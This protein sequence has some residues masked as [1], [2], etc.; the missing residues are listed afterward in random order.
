MSGEFGWND[1]TWSLE[2]D[3]TFDFLVQ[4]GLMF[5]E[6]WEDFCSHNGHC[7]GDNDID[8]HSRFEGL[9]KEGDPKIPKGLKHP[10]KKCKQK[11]EHGVGEPWRDFDEN[12]PLR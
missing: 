5:S 8:W 11:T 6:D 7:K 12:P 4:T 1:G 10:F 2:K 3:E 9:R